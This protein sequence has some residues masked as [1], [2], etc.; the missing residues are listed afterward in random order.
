MTPKHCLD[1]LSIPS[2][3]RGTLILAASLLAGAIAPAQQTTER[4][5]VDSIEN[6]GNGDSIC[7]SVSEDGRYVAFQSEASNLILGDGNG[8]KDVFVR[9]RQT[10]VTKCISFST[11]GSWET[12]YPEC[13]RS[14]WTAATWRSIALASNLVPGDTNGIGDVFVRDRQVEHHRTRQRR[15]VRQSGE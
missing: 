12:G 8:L 15:L 6:Q 2:I 9:D 4:V 7:P 13:R 5:S 14:P 11:S 3:H 1:S 10:G